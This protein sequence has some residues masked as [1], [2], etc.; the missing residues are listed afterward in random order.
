MRWLCGTSFALHSDGLMQCS[1]DKTNENKQLFQSNT[2]HPWDKVHWLLCYCLDNITFILDLELIQKDPNTYFNMTNCNVRVIHN[3]NNLSDLA[4]PVVWMRF[5][6]R[7]VM[8]EL[9]RCAYSAFMQLGK[10]YS[11]SQALYLLFWTYTAD[12]GLL[13]FLQSVSKVCWYSFAC[14]WI[15]NQP[16]T[17]TVMFRLANA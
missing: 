1:F 3:I 6:N 8:D 13:L 17:H 11:K 9:K 14:G 5:A 12:G 4:Q 7:N 10:Y 15:I 2:F 16:I